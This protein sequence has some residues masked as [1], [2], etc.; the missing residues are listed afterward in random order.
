MAHADQVENHKGQRKAMPPSS[1]S[2]FTLIEMMAVVMIVGLMA[3]GA[4]VIFSQGGPKKDLHSAVE[5]FTQYGQRVA[6]FS[7]LN[8]EPMGLV[9]TPPA[10]SKA[11][12]EH[13]TWSY[14]W[15]RFVEVPSTNAN[16]GV[17]D[18]LDMEGL[19]AVDLDRDVELYV[20][21]EGGEWDWEAG[22]ESELPILVV[23]PSG[24]IEPSLFE[25]EF[26]HRNADLEP[27]HVNIDVSG[28]LQWQEKVEEMEAL[29]E[30]LRN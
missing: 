1:A 11:D 5:K 6:D 19:P 23:Y 21:I 9:L 20:R 15:R 3:A 8:G 30:R 7:V 24:E 16:G 18:W 2:G 26:A 14:R 27:Q 25:V 17:I 22:I 29:E 13:R 10:W 28:Y 12:V 4:T